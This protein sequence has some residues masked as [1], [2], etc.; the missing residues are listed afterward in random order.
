MPNYLPRIALASLLALAGCQP[1]RPPSMQAASV[2]DGKGYLIFNAP[3]STISRD[4]FIAD[5]ETFR[6]AGATEIELAINSP[7]GDIDAAQGIVDY[8]TRVHEQNGVSFEV[9]N[10]GLVASAATYVFLHA[11]HRYSQDRGTFLFHAA[12]VVSNVPASAEK[13]REQAAKLDAYERVVRATLKE[14]SNLTDA[15]TQTYVRRT[16]LLNADDARR[17]GVIEGIAAYL[18]PKGIGISVI[19][20]KPNPAAAAA[21]PA[22]P[23]VQ[24]GR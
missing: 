14:R 7:G 21:P 9:Y 11:Q 18:P 20:F 15:E 6:R 4:L 17:D 10:V 19:V 5:V 1:P 3:I 8:M 12:G 23:L 13:L 24:P 22:T 2:V 16:V